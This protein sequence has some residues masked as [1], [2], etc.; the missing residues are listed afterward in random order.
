ML[1]AST[2]IIGA[3]HFV[4]SADEFH[5]LTLSAGDEVI[6]ANG[7]YS[8]DDN[9]NFSGDGTA[10]NPITLRA[11]TPGEVVFT[12]GMTMTIPGDHV[13]VDGFYW[14]GGDGRNNHI[15]FR[16]NTDYANHS[17]IRN[18]GINDLTASGT[19]KH[20][21]I[22]LY[23]TNNTVENCSFVNKRSPGALILVE[24]DYH[25][26]ATP[27]G[28]TIRN[29][30]FYNYEYRDPESTHS[31]DSETIRIGSSSDQAKSASTVV[32]NN[33]FQACDGENEIIT[34][35]STDNSYLHNTFRNCHGSLV[36][37]HGANARVE[38]NFFLGE[39]KVG[40]GG[41]RVSD[42]FHTI[43]NNYFQD[44]NNADDK[45]NN[46]ITLVGGSDETGGTS[47]GYQKVDGILVAFNTVY[48]CDDPLF[49]NDR[50]SYDPTGVFAYNLLHST[51]SDAVGGDISGTGQGMSYVGNMVSVSDIGITDPGFAMVSPG[52]VADGEIHR[53]SSSSP[54]SGAAGSDYSS[55]VDFDI[56]GKTR[57]DSDM[58]VGAHEVSGG[59][60]S[61]AHAPHTDDDVRTL[62][63][64][65]F[66]NAAGEYVGDSG[67]GTLSVG[68]PPE[69]PH[70]AGSVAISVSCD[71][72]WSAVEEEDWI[73]IAPSSGTGNGSVTISVTE[74]TS[75]SGRSGTITFTTE[76]LTRSVTVTQS[77]YVEPV[78]GPPPSR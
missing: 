23:G 41:I 31:G 27:V 74:N 43:I 12:G 75:G 76:S 26:A 50:S 21:W 69:F 4:S 78:P 5:S 36:L 29:N 28:H 73:S 8:D 60:G 55:M 59:V 38:G 6:W 39:N 72:V 7:T 32:E 52:F 20:R 47:N 35:K 51:S 34:N 64:A 66:L 46:A 22:V 48:H 53:P 49:Y 61:A 30:Y 9:I 70:L 24:L 45:W 54:V 42:S 77:A 65:G 16:N 19:D 58:D 56:E 3:Q 37:R 63:G 2:R 40:S 15:Q 67:V 18:C 13:V 25:D 68:S 44:L 10:S 33:Y 14:S 17:T 71:V 62:V 57:P 11:E 1:A